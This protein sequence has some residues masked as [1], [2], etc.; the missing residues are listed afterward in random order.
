MEEELDD[1]SGG[2]AEWQH[3]LEAFWRDFKPK[4]DEVMERKPSEVT[5]ALDEFLSD[6]LFPKQ[7]D[8]GD[9]RLCPKCVAKAAKAAACRCA[10]A[11]SARSSPA[12]IIPS[13]RYRRKFGQP[14][15][16]EGRRG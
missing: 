9:P 11:V 6:Y 15:E 13:A 3:V 14:G 8:G 4:T 16:G 2:R 5:E 10:A 12:R 7:A 1:V